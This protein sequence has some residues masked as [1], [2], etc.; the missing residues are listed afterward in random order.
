M[1]AGGPKGPP[2]AARSWITTE[3]LRPRTLCHMPGRRDTPDHRGWPPSFRM[4]RYP[5]ELTLRPSGRSAG[6]SSLRRIDELWLGGR[7]RLE[8]HERDLARRARAVA[9]PVAVV[10]GRP[11]PQALALGGGRLARVDAA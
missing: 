5:A 1:R 11:G 3:L 9:G 2:V 8:Q 7:S 4:A 6:P 10:L